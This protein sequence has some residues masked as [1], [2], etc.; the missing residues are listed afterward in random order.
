[1]TTYYKEVVDAYEDFIAT[2]ELLESNNIFVLSGD[3]YNNVLTIKTD[4]VVPDTIL[5]AL[6]LSLVL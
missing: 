1:M 3:I 6:N 5:E 2:R 4:V